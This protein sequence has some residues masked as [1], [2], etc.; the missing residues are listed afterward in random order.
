MISEV[1]YTVFVPNDLSW[2]RIAER[3]IAKCGILMAIL[4]IKLVEES[5]NMQFAIT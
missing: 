1:L 3:H 4:N 2:L 5:Y